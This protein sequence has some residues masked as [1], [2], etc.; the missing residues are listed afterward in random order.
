ME[1]NEV[2]PF[3]GRVEEARRVYVAVSAR[4][5]VRRRLHAGRRNRRIDRAR[6]RTYAHESAL[7]RL[8]EEIAVFAA[9]GVS[10]AELQRIAMH[11]QQTIAMLTPE[12]RDLAELD[13][14]EARID[15][16]EDRRQ[17]QRL[18]RRGAGPGALLE[19]AECRDEVAALNL[20]MSVALRQMAHGQWRSVL[21]V[22]S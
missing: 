16:L 7:A 4:H 9:A 22:M 11:V 17:I 20:E 19:E 2:V 5:A 18:T 1:R 3:T 13:Q 6:A 15:G 10:R 8:D 12:P 21:K 14:L